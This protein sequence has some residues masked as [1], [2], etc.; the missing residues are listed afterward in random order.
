MN[1]KALKLKIALAVDIHVLS[2][3]P[4][5]KREIVKD[6]VRMVVD[7]DYSLADIHERDYQYLM[8]GVTSEMSRH[9]T[10]VAIERCGIVPESLRGT[11]GNIPAFFLYFPRRW[12][13]CQMD[14][15][16]YGYS[17]TF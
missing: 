8:T 14:F 17:G 7:E 11:L 1:S 13:G 2:D 5:S 16:T 9:L 12:E 3:K 4:F 6:L 15:V 10:D